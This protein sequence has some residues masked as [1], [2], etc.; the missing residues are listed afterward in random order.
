VSAELGGYLRDATDLIALVQVGPGRFRAE[1][2]GRVSITGL[3]LGARVR[4]RDHLT[5]TL[6]GALVD[7]A[8]VGDDGGDR[9]ERP[10]GSVGGPLGERGG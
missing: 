8:L 10:W 3:E 2:F 1:N 9:E 4:W 5:L 7:P 6:A